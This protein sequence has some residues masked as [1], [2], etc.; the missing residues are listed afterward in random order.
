MLRIPCPKC[1][2]PLYTPNPESFQICYN[3]GTFF[4]GKHGLDR[5]WE[6]R[7]KQEKP[8]I[9][10]HQGK[11]WNTKTVDL[12]SKG[13]GLIISGDPAILKGDILR[14]EF[15]NTSFTGKIVWMK[16]GS[17]KTQIGLTRQK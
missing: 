14:F 7:C 5:R 12:S 1:Q 6:K 17:D 3:C 13:V 15:E 8:F 9:F 4:S 16:K 10:F 11:F 2:K